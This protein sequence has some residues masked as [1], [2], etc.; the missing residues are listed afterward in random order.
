MDRYR[1]E[2]KR[3]DLVEG[4][5]IPFAVYQFIDR[6][7][8]TL[9]LSKGFCDLFGFDD[10]DEAYYLMDNDMYRDVHPDDV[11]R[12]ANEAVRFATEGGSY[13]VV[14]RSRAPKHEDYSIVHAYGKHVYTAEGIRLAIVWYVD[15]G[16]YDENADAE[17]FLLS[18]YSKLLRQTGMLRESSYDTLT[19]LPNMA[20]FF[21][22]ADA[23]RKSVDEQGGRAAIIY[24]DLVGMKTFNHKYGFAEGDRLLRSIAKVLVNE[25]SNE[26]CGRLGH[27]HFG[28]FTEAV[29]LEGKLERVIAACA[30][31][32]GG[33]TL[34]V[35]FGVYVGEPERVGAAVACDR[36]KMACDLNRGT[37]V[38]TYSFFDD[39]LRERVERR[40]Y[41][42]ENLD[43]ALAGGWIQAYFQP[44]VDS[45]TGEVCDCEALA[46]W[47]DPVRGIISPGEFVPILEGARLVH[48]IDLQIIDDVVACLSARAAAGE[49]VVPVSV[50]LSR[51][52]FDAC[53]IIE[54]LRRRVDEAGVDRS[55]INVEITESVVGC[56][57]K[58]MLGQ[59]DRLHELG[60]NV[61][62]DDF[63]SGYSSLDVLQHFDFDLIKFDMHFV[64]Q[65]GSSKKSRVILTELMH[66]AHNLGIESLCEGAET[67]EQVD[68]LRDIGCGRI[69]GYYFGRPAPAKVLELASPQTA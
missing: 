53:D 68:F 20:Y 7:V 1:F 28:A 46:R 14:Y 33:N 35:R 27:D 52:D 57:Y 31:A 25:F 19:G 63:G 39:S 12:I 29:D 16:V 64:R 5:P 23:H 15:E 21:E 36:A 18:T 22:L 61:W 47:V 45:K 67:R 66:M 58:Y 59:V 3:L 26:S 9:M 37:F 69:Q 54:E 10:P 65:L 62:M 51:V 49:R 11:S 32:N 38:S 42:L 41:I 13:E 50:N 40:T 34:P 24:M 17:G 6:R 8:V 44:I 60:F 48:K 56:D 2:D 30:Q 4:S 55:L 43:R